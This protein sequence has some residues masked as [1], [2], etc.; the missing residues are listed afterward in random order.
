MFD[1]NFLNV[2]VFFFD[3]VMVILDSLWAVFAWWAYWTVLDGIG[4][5]WMVILITTYPVQFA[6]VAGIHP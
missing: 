1:K 2:R 3:D 5:V 4:K 6:K